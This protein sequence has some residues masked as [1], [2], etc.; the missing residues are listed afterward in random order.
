MADNILKEEDTEMKNELNPLKEE[1]LESSTAEEALEF[2]TAEETPE[3]STADETYS[4][5]VKEED[6]KVEIKGTFLS[7]L[8]S[9]T[10][11][12]TQAFF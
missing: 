8:Q 3:S 12:F 1:T 6:V 2:S 5:Y 7:T 10:Q 9:A 4:V 11:K